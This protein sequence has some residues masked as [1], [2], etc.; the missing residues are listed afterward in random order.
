MTE[1]PDV[2]GVKPKEVFQEI[3]SENLWEVDLDADPRYVPWMY[4]SNIIGRVLARMTGQGPL[5]PV[6]VKCTKE[7]NLAVVSRGGAFDDYERLEHAFS[8][9]G[10]AKEF[11]FSQQVERIDIFTYDGKVDYQLTR[12]GVKAYGDK[13]ELFTDSFYSLDFYT[14]RVK[15][16]CK[17]YSPKESGTETSHVDNQINCSTATFLTKGVK[18]GDVVANITKNLYASVTILNAETKLTL[19]ENIFTATGAPWDDYSVEGA[20]L[21]LMGWFRSDD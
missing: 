17:S 8:A 18:V 4:I 13:I 3:K 14:L 7:G 15:A 19:S 21:K 16:T 9:A 2:K 12:D 6:T 10:E 20:R 11:T 5:G 1:P